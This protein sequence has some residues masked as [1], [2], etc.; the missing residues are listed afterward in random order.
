M[1]NKR[2][3]APSVINKLDE[4]LLINNPTVWST[5]IHMV[6]YYGMLFL[7]FL[8]GLSWL[9]PNDARNNTNIEVWSTLI[10]TVSLIGIVFWIIYLLRFNVFKRFGAQKRGDALLNFLFYFIA[11]GVFVVA[12]FVPSYV[13]TLRAQKAYSKKEIYA[14]ID[15]VNT[16]ICQLEYD[17]I[18]HSWDSR[19]YYLDNSD[20]SKPI[21]ED[22][23]IVTVNSSSILDSAD[24]ENTLKQADS[25]VLIKKGVARI[26][27][28]P[29]YRF[30]APYRVNSDGFIF[31]PYSASIETPLR[32]MDSK[33]LYYTVLK[34]FKRP[35]TVAIKKELTALIN[36]YTSNDDAKAYRAYYESADLQ[37]YFPKLKR[38]YNLEDMDDSINNILSKQDRWNDD[39][40]EIFLHIFFYVTICLV[41]L[42]FVFRHS[43][44]KTFFL[45][46]LTAIIL[47][48][49][50][51]LLLTTSRSEGDLAFGTFVFY[52][53]VFAGTSMAVY[54]TST[55]RAITGIALN[56]FVFSTTFLPLVLYGW[57]YSIEDRKDIVRS[58]AYYEQKELNFLVAEIAGA[59]LLLALIETV[60]KPL[61]RKWW[62]QPE[63]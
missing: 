31:A 52:Y 46:L 54:S 9:A 14:D 48:I 45:T 15:K 11:I 38:K 24:F 7:L 37:G 17:S 49:I 43:T 6:L 23:D 59:V 5:R 53:L 62:A 12:P 22:K 32:I 42:L 30:L 1:K 16:M 36:K 56:L 55:R 51:T 41:L 18:P 26:Y 13:E 44:A 39:G 2:P 4:H 10:A 60:F 63:N 8:F 3:F 50:T 27:D 35:D 19:I 29:D 20:S 33:K 61:Y 40:W 57:Y 25:F 58:S 34:N 21:S 28:C 47:T